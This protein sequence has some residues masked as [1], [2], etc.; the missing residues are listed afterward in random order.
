LDEFELGIE[1][2]ES[3]VFDLLKNPGNCDF[4]TKGVQFSRTSIQVNSEFDYTLSDAFQENG[5]TD[6]LQSLGDINNIEFDLSE[7][8]NVN[9]N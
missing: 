6:T 5:I 3:P 9:Y 4:K 7:L 1:D 2:L 8:E